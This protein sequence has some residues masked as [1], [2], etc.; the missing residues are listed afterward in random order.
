MNKAKTEAIIVQN[1]GSLYEDTNLGITWIRNSFKTLGTY[2]TLNYKET[3]IL[4]INH[5]V[6]IIKD[7][8]NAWEASSLSLKGKITVVKAYVIPHI[9]LLAS[10]YQ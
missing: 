7:I 6:Q 1:D 8:L 2:F 3:A 10:T 5:K 4:N 9:H